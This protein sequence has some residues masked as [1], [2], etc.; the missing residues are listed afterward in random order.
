MV[1]H[2][3]YRLDLSDERLLNGDQPVQL[4]NKAFQLLRLFVGNP[5]QLLTKDNILDGVWRDVCVSEGLVKEYVHDLRFALGDDAKHPKF[6]ETVHGRGYR[7]LGGVEELSRADGVAAVMKPRAQPPSLAV[8]PFANLTGKERWD[9]FCHGLG[10]DLIIDIARYPDLMVIASMHTADGSDSHG[11]TTDYALNGSVQA[12]DT[13]VRVN[14]KLTETG[15]G[16]HIWTDQYE[17]ELGEFF[18][19]QSDIVGQVV[20]AVGG[21]S[22]RIP[23]AERLRLG[24]TPPDDLHAYE[25]YLLGHELEARFEKE[26]TLRAFELMQRAVKLDPDYARAWLVRGWTCWQILLEEWANDTQEYHELWRESFLR[27]ATLDPLDP[28]AMMELAGVRAGDEDITGARDALERALD[29]GRNQADLL[30]SS[31]NPI[32]LILDDPRRAKQILDR[33]LELIAMVG[34]WQRLSMARVAYFT[35]DFERAVKD[36]RRGPDNLLTQLIEI[37]SLAQLGCREEVQSLV[38]AFRAQHASF[39]P[40]EFMK[41]YPITATGARELFL[42]GVEKAGLN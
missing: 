23:H 34:D 41:C 30:I 5:N 17:R 9:R 4:T 6:I 27:A 10:D 22:G 25:L 38:R 32:A 13:K 7:F 29:L 31:A 35:K 36:A 19:I 3:K 24:R 1:E 28:L 12:S 20:S 21:F 42:D 8:L 18:A 37:L 26:S 11:L 33:G 40:R 14:V 16:T 15:S 39:D 2:V